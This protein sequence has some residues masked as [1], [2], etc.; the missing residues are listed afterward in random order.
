MSRRNFS[1]RLLRHR[2]RDRFPSI[3]PSLLVLLSLPGCGLIG[4]IE[5]ELP[6]TAVIQGISSHIPG[7]VGG[8][9]GWANVSGT[10]SRTIANQGVKRE[11]LRSASL[12]EAR[13]SVTLP[14][15][16]HLGYIESFAVY[17]EAP[18]LER[19]R[20][21]HASEAFASRPNRVEMDIEDVDLLDYVVAEQLSLIPEVVIN[22][23]PSID[24]EIEI[25]L[26]LELV[27]SL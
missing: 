15:D 12:K 9:N 19:R 27:P 25:V 13:I 4:P 14:E 16:G 7:A 8:D 10:I 21:A 24:H 3:L 18:G 1:R 22:H 2:W 23:P 26:V 20:L 17:I 5:V 11:H 6:A